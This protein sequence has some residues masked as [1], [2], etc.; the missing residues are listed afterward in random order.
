MGV[1]TQV[2]AFPVY[3][4]DELKYRIKEAFTHVPNDMLDNTGRELHSRKQILQANCGS[5]I[6]VS[7]LLIVILM[8]ISSLNAMIFLFQVQ[9]NLIFDHLYTY[10]KG[11]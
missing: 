10:F 3:Y 5:N 1:K 9:E 4:T 11:L 2:N 8:K 7:E 6:E